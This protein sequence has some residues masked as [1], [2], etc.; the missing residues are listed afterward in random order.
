MLQTIKFGSEKQRK[1]SDLYSCPSPLKLSRTE[2]P[3][4]RLATLNMDD[5]DPNFLDSE[6]NYPTNGNSKP[7]I[8]IKSTDYTDSKGN[9]E[10]PTI[11]KIAN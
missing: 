1:D 7:L 11:D 10:S 9:Q 3:T 2:S 6:E 8:K 4:L 5:D